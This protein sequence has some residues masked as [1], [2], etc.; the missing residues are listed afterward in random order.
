METGT[1]S[2]PTVHCIQGQVTVDWKNC[3]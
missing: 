2:A 1:M 3:Q